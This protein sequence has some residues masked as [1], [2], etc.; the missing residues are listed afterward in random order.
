MKGQKL[1]AAGAA[2]KPFA[3]QES[4]AGMSSPG[5]EETG[6]GGLS[7]NFSC[8]GVFALETTPP[9]REALVAKNS[10]PG[11][12]PWNAFLGTTSPCVKSRS[13][14]FK[15]TKPDSTKLRAYRKKIIL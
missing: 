1:S 15:Q 7:S 11:C 4:Y 5:G 12:A 6:E 9:L 14:Q 10:S 3:N 2:Q 8:L 13:T